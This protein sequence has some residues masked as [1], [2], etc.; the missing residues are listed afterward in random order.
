[1]QAARNTAPREVADE[2]RMQEKRAAQ[3]NVREETALKTKIA[4]DKQQKNVVWLVRSK[5]LFPGVAALWLHPS[6]RAGC[7]PLCLQWPMIFT[8]HRVSTSLVPLTEPNIGLGRDSACCSA[9]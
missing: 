5:P 2:V 8:V 4:K 3:K 6:G 7:C 1:M 9:N